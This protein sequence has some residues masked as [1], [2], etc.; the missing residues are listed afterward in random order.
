[1]NKALILT[2]VGWLICGALIAYAIGDYYHSAV[3][4]HGVIPMGFFALMYCM[5][6]IAVGLAFTSI[7]RALK[8]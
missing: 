4:G 2:I 6:G 3:T 1:M 5:G 8:G 7:G